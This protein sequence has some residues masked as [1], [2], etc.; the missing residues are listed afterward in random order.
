MQLSQSQVADEVKKRIPACI[1]QQMIAYTTAAKPKLWSMKLGK[2][3][4]HH[5]M[6]ALLYKDCTVGY[7]CLFKCIQKWIKCSS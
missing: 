3:L 5:F 1:L 2:D 7:H 4:V 6:L